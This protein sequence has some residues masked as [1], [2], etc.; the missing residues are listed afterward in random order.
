MV[1]LKH[2]SHN[3]LTGLAA[4]VQIKQPSSNHVLS[5]TGGLSSAFAIPSEHLTLPR[6]ALPESLTYIKSV[7]TNS[8]SN[9]PTNSIH[10]TRSQSPYFHA[11]SMYSLYIPCTII[12]RE[13]LFDYHPVA[14]TPTALLIRII[15]TPP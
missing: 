12:I 14:T 1:L 6:L 10:A 7:R 15:I 2:P 8:H 4:R 5:T 3:D 13:E 9:L 11:S